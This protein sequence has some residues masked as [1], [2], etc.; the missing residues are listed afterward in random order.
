MLCVYG[1]YFYAC[2]FDSD[3]LLISCF[4]VSLLLV[5]GIIMYM[6]LTV[7]IKCVLLLFPA[8]FLLIC[9]LFSCTLFWYWF[10]SYFMLC[11]I[12]AAYLLLVSCFLC[13]CFFIVKDIKFYYFLQIFCLCAIAQSIKQAANKQYINMTKAGQWPAKVLLEGKKIQEYTFNLSF[14]INKSQQIINVFQQYT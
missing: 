3:F 8:G 13:F 11:F 10:A 2:H 1:T 7:K 9:H 14:A 6:F 12:F 4:A 5:C